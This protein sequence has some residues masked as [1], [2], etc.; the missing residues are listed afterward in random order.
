LTGSG[1]LEYCS[2]FDNIGQNDAW[3]LFTLWII[4]K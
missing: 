4:P 2:G 3:T 1:V